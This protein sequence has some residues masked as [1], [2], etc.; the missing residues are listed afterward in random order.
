M[1]DRKTMVN[2]D[3]MKT[4]QECMDAKGDQKGDETHNGDSDSRTD[5]GSQG[6]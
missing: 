1:T 2:G 4:G 3:S 6:G 5:R